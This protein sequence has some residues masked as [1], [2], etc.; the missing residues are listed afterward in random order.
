MKWLDRILGRNERARK[1]IDDELAAHLAMRTQDNLASGMNAEQAEADA[2]ERFGDPE[3]A[4]R[5]C[6]RVRTRRGRV[7]LA[8]AAAAGAIALTAVALVVAGETPPAHADVWARVAPFDGIRWNGETPEVHVGD[9]WFRL[10]SIDGIGAAALIEASRR[11]FGE[12]WRK[13][14]EEDIV[15]VIRAAGGDPGSTVSLGLRDLDQARFLVIEDVEMTS[16][17][18]QAIM[19]AKHSEGGA[20]ASQGGRGMPTLAPFDA[21]EWT[22]AAPRVRVHGEWVTLLAIDGRRV[23]DIVAFARETYP[24]RPGETRPLWQK[25]F[26]EDLVEVLTRMGQAPGAEVDL[27]VEDPSGAQRTLEDVAMTAENRRELW[28]AAQLRHP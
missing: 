10:E 21:I 12:R 2:R 18:R 17:K 6:E 7:G 23:E 25:R 3:G 22:A 5:A 19:R 16:E 24:D 1:D 20:S 9:R 4:A 26:E 15:E 8:L 28:K 11:E 13:R 27:I 14:V